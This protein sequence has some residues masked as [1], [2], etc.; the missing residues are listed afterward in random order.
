MPQR[1]EFVT[2]FAERIGEP[3]EKRASERD[4]PGRIA[5]EHA[6]AGENGLDVLLKKF[7]EELV[8]E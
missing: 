6:T 2:A 7:K 8:N 3:R 1:T 5:G 4:G